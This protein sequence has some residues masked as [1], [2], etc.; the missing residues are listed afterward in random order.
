MARAVAAAAPALSGELRTQTDRLHAQIEDLLG[1]PSSV[2]T[3]DDYLAWLGHFLGFYEPL[4][5]SLARF[6]EWEAFGFAPSQIRAS[7][8][9]SDLAALG[10]DPRRPCRVSRD[11]LPALPTFAHA[12]GAFYVLE[13]ASLGGRVILRDLEARMGAAIAGATQFFGGRGEATGPMWQSFRVA[14]D[15]FGQAH[16]RLCTDVV[17]G[18]QRTFRAMLTWFAPFCAAIER[19]A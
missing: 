1:L 8:L 15:S 3:R 7:C 10:A 6:L 19:R 18:A 4:E 2:R 16:P 11:L 17:T 5:C 12:L 14:L 13:G 9:A